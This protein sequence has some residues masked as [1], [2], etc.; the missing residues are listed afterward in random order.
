MHL[1]LV[2]ND[3]VLLQNILSYMFRLERRTFWEILYVHF[4]EDGSGERK[5][6]KRVY[7]L[8]IGFKYLSTVSTFCWSYTAIYL[9]SLLIYVVCYPPRKMKHF[10]PLD[11]KRKTF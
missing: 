11:F 9:L 10:E 8:I 7:F 6:V 4:P 3:I 2:N 5:H 1:R